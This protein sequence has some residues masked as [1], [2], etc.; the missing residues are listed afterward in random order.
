ME[1]ADRYRRAYTIT[2]ADLQVPL[3]GKHISD[4]VKLRKNGGAYINVHTSQNQ[5]GEIREESSGMSSPSALTTSSS[6]KILRRNVIKYVM[7][8]T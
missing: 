1:Y 5:N 2:S 3:A 8:R 6:L 7:I 4:L